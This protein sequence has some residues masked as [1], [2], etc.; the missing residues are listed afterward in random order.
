[1]RDSFGRVSAVVVAA[2]VLSLAQG[3]G[4]STAAP[5]ATKLTREQI[6]ARLLA[7]QGGRLFSN[8]ARLALG[9]IEHHGAHQPADPGRGQ[10]LG[11]VKPASGGLSAAPSG[12]LT[13]V[14]VN[15]PAEDSHQPDQTTQSET[16]VAV[17]G[18]HVVVGFNDSQ[19]T[20]Q[21][22]VLA[23]A[24]LTG[25]AYSNDGGASFTDGGALPLKPEFINVGDPWLA[26]DRAGNVYFSQ[27]QLDYFNFNLDIG[28]A[29]ST[30]GGHTWS[31]PQPIT[32]PPFEVFY[33]GD[34][35]AVAVGPD[36]GGERRMAFRIEGAPTFRVRS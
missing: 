34:K 16:A 32:R 13:N 8:G 11:Q 30:D 31:Q 7:R 28:V 27:L 1:M 19:Q 24:N 23:S 20:L 5:P 4:L 15:D 18:T 26:S 36:P 22:F 6:A 25:F 12:G 10:G 21:P 9:A 17:T 3:A 14:R 2:L 35:E 33:T 29:K